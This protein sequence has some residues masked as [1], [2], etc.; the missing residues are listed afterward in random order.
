MV[1]TFSIAGLLFFVL[2][3]RRSVGAYGIPR[4][5]AFSS[6][7]ASFVFDRLRRNPISKGA[8]FYL[9]P[10]NR[11]CGAALCA[12]I[13]LVLFPA[14]E[15]RQR[16]PG[17]ASSYYPRDSFDAGKVTA[18]MDGRCRKGTESGASACPCS[19]ANYTRRFEGLAS[20]SIVGNRVMEAVPVTGIPPWDRGMGQ[21]EMRIFRFDLGQ[22]VRVSKQKPRKSRNAVGQVGKPWGSFSPAILAIVPAVPARPCM[23]GGTGTGTWRATS[24]VRV[25]RAPCSSRPDGRMC[26][27]PP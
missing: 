25:F 22:S 24:A 26:L 21:G 6:H 27:Y 8:P 13:R 5:P 17:V 2:R 7:P 3:A 12:L 11:E 23:R 18:V 1:P 9:A 16:S 20:R 10:A 19:V 15:Q 14:P 4:R